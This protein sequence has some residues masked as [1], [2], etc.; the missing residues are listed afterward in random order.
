MLPRPPRIFEADDILSGR[1]SLD[2]YPFGLI[3]LVIAYSSYYADTPIH[4]SDLPRVD[5]LLSAAEL[6][7]TRGWQIA[8][9]DSGGKL[10]CLRRPQ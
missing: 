6:L 10:I 5:V 3:Y 1:V 4:P 2:G 9:V 8:G 7:E